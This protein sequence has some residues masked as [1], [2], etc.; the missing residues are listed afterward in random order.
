MNIMIYKLDL[1]ITSS[2]E[3]IDFYDKSH[4]ESYLEFALDLN[5]R[6]LAKYPQ[7]DI[8]KV[9]IYLH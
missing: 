4:D 3:Y 7:D 1:T 9:N 8:A 6:Y 5:Q 2:L